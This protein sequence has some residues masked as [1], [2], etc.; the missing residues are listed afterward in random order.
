M[1]IPCLVLVAVLALVSGER[2]R[3]DNYRVYDVAIENVDQLQ[4]MQYLE[5]YPDGVRTFVLIC[6]K[7]VV[8]VNAISVHLLGI[9]G[10]NW[11]ES[12]RDGTTT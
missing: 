8:M 9:S 3:F 10:S 5:Q 7:K 1:R 11:N 6:I 2:V 4:V 12:K